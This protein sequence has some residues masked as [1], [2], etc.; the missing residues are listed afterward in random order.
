MTGVQLAALVHKKTKTNTTTFTL[1]DMLVYA[2]IFKDEI[3]SKIQQR[4]SE[5]WNIPSLDDLADDQREY[6]FPSDVLNNIVSLE[7]KFS[8][9]GDYVIATPLARRHYADVLQESKI[10]NDFDNLDPRYFIRRQ[11]IYIL[12]GTI[13]EVTDGFK[14]VYN[15]FP[16]DLADL[17][18]LA[19]L[20]VDPT[21]TTHG[22]PREFH[23]LW[24]RRVGIE[25][26]NNNDM[27]LSRKDLEYD[28]DLEATLDEFSIPNLDEEIVGALPPASHRGDDGYDY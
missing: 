13:V 27:A 1:A 26:K 16:A 9:A 11:A 3:A 14:L 28:R 10:V 6:A 17:E 5:I 4:R 25:Y 24:A 8:A 22:F 18:G 7:L 15:A 19:D 21:T 20:S 12:S 2:N 23:E